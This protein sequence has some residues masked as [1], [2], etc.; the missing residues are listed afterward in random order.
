MPAAAQSR[1]SEIFKDPDFLKLSSEQKTQVFSKVEPEFASLS[2]A[3]QQQ[4][5][6]AVQKRSTIRSLGNSSPAIGQSIGQSDVDKFITSS[7]KPEMTEK[8][9]GETK[10]DQM[11]GGITRAARKITS[12]E[13][14]PISSGLS[15]LLGILKLPFQTAAEEMDRTPRD[16]MEKFLTRTGVE[17]AVFPG[18]LAAKRLLVDPAAS[19]LKEETERFSEGRKQGDP[20]KMI[21]GGA[22]TILSAIPGLGPFGKEIAEQA[23]TGDVLGAGAKALTAERGVKGL[24]KTGAGTVGMISRLADLRNSFPR[25]T[26]AFESIAKKAN[27][28]PVDHTKAYAIAQKAVELGKQGYTVPKPIT[29]FIQFIDERSKSGATAPVPG[30]PN[31]RIDT[32]GSSNPL[33]YQN[34]RNFVSSLGSAIDW[35]RAAGSKGGP[36]HRLATGLRHELDSQVQS[37]LDP[38]GERQNYLKAKKDF[39]TSIAAMRR[40]GFI[41]K[42]GGKIAGFGTGG[43]LGHPFV[44]GTLGS[45]AGE[46]LGKSGGERFVGKPDFERSSSSSPPAAQSPQSPQRA[47]TEA[48]AKRDTES[49]SKAR[50][51]LGPSADLRAVIARA[52]EI[53]KDFAESDPTRRYK[54]PNLSAEKSARIASIRQNLQSRI[55]NAKTGGERSI[56]VAALRKFESEQS[57]YRTPESRSSSDVLNQINRNVDKPR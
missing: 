55:D 22:G 47:G 23:G 52:L 41:G 42:L 40:F 49:M 50:T 16:S 1:Q 53:N 48:G 9:A 38:I 32:G 37:T 10:T 44:G 2:P 26:Q 25:A 39:E 18:S 27:D 34:A 29:D 6:D 36:M 31:A 43:A 46:V 4:F 12:A 54:G 11:F 57:G 8:Q 20:L 56:A 14:T 13:Q 35:D 45:K 17:S 30:E 51:E 7:R 5:M 28:L 21:E 3:Q 15:G 24:A 33:V 19:M